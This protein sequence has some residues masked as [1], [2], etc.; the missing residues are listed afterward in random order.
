MKHK[1]G[2][3]V[4]CKAIRGERGFAAIVIAIDSKYYDVRSYD[5]T[6]WLRTEKELGK[7]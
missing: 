2:D 6:V 1:T 3:V 5:G 4:W 7:E